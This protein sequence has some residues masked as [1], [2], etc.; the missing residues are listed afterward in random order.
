[1]F[2]HAAG[3]T[4]CDDP[5]QFLEARMTSANAS[6][7]TSQPLIFQPPN[8]PA[9]HGTFDARDWE[10]LSRYWHPVAFSSDVK[11]TPISATLLDEP[12]V[13]FRSNGAVVAASDI[14]PH[15]SAA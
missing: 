6:S 11:E 9:R 14:C 12:L 2:V 4:G 8:G 5:H 10:I 7:F 3:L 1:L 13:V 15:R